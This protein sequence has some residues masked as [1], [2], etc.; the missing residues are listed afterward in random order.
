[1]ELP[2]NRYGT[3]LQNDMCEWHQNVYFSRMKAI[4][5]DLKVVYDLADRALHQR[6][7]RARRFSKGLEISREHP[8]CS[9]RLQRS[10]SGSLK[11]SARS[12]VIGAH[13]T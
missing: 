10:V 3:W 2:F 4:I 8:D 12:I 6:H 9:N 7:T 5:K 1:M 11:R 13:I